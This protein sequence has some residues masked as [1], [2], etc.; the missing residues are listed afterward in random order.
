MA[1]RQFEVY[2]PKSVFKSLRKIPIPWR[3]RILEAIDSLKVNPYLGEK[4][5]GELENRRK[6]RIWPYRI[7]YKI[8]EAKKLIVIVEAKHRQGVYK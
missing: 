2:I 1:N 5:W 7:I 8:D 6:I 4:L 3:H